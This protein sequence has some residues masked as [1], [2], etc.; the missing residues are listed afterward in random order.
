VVDDVHDVKAELCFHQFI[1]VGRLLLVFLLVV[2]FKWTMRSELLTFLF[3]LLPYSDRKRI[4]DLPQF[5]FLASL[6]SRLLSC[7]LTFTSNYSCMVPT[8]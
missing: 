5:A 3:G 6:L 4:V 1:S 8:T 2:L 7:L